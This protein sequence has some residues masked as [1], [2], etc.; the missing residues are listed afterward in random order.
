MLVGSRETGE[1][2]GPWLGLDVQLRGSGGR[3]ASC[4]VV[5]AD[6][7]GDAICDGGGSGSGIGGTGGRNISFSGFLYSMIETKKLNL[8]RNTLLDCVHDIDE[9]KCVSAV[10]ECVAWSVWRKTYVAASWAE[11]GTL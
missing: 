9:I 6:L 7:R 3:S 8:E 10:V 1:L 11:L 2:C 5:V 4:E